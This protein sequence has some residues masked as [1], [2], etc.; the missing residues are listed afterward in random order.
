MVFLLI[1]A[2]FPERRDN[3]T[4]KYNHIFVF[5]SVMVLWLGVE[6]PRA[7]QRGKQEVMGEDLGSAAQAG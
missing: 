4:C 3:L 7:G 5:I 2:F 1:L 6:P